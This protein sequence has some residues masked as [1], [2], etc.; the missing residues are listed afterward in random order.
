MHPKPASGHSTRLWCVC[1]SALKYEF[2]YAFQAY[3]ALLAVFGLVSRG[4]V[5]RFL[6]PHTTFTLLAVVAC[7]AYRDVWPTTTYT[8]VPQDAADGRALWAKVALALFA[9]VLV[10]VLQ[11]HYVPST[12]PPVRPRPLR[13]PVC[14]HVR[15]QRAL[16]PVDRASLFSRTFFTFLDPLILAASRVPHLPFEAFPPMQDADRAE[17]LVAQSAA[18]MARTRAGTTPPLFWALVRVFRGELAQQAMWLVG[19][20]SMPEACAGAAC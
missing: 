20:V 14:A 10:P 17:R 13:G 7:Y 11:P 16:S 18:H 4:S 15:I 8:R 1:I 19:Y 12:D 2:K 3:V 9:G 5:S 6:S